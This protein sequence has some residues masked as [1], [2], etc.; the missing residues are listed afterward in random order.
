VTDQREIVMD[1][2]EQRPLEQ[3]TTDSLSS[4]SATWQKDLLP[5]MRRTLTG[6]TLFF[7]C[8]TCLQLVYLNQSILSAPKVDVHEAVSLLSVGPQSTNQ[9]ILAA[10][11]LKA[12]LSLEA[13]ALNSQ[14]H[15]AG[16]LLMSR[17]W[18]TYLGFVTGMI[19]ALVGAAFILGKLEEKTSE[20]KTQVAN[21]AD[22]SFKSASPGLILAVLGVILMITSIVTHYTIDVTHRAIYLSESQALP[23]EVIGTPPAL[24]IPEVKKSRQ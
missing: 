10:A 11:R 19:L 1:S 21:V 24:V 7:F 4:L 15:Q 17:L 2:V 6:L 16:V 22:V 20:L 5:L 8:A 18:T 12:V 14:Y 13:T 9:E 3:K 23:P